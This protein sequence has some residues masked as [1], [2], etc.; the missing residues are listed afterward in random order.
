MPFTEGEFPRI[1][2]KLNWL[3]QVSVLSGSQYSRPHLTSYTT[4]RSLSHDIFF[5]I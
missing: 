5:S 3:G 1:V 2:D 4:V